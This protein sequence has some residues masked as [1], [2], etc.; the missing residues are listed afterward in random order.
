MISV[1]TY[2]LEGAQRLVSCTSND[3][4]EERRCSIVSEHSTHSSREFDVG[5]VKVVEDL[6]L[7]FRW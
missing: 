3:T 5:S 1:W 6:D 2:V 4:A 7:E